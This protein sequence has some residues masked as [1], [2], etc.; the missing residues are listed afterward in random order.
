MNEIE[1]KLEKVFTD[2]ANTRMA[3][4]PICNPVLRVQAVG[5]R[6]WQEHWVGV[7]V[8]PWTISL[9]LMPGEKGPLKTLGADEK[10]TWE[11]PSGNYEFMGLNEP[12]LGSCQVCSLISPV[13]DVA[14][15][16]DAVTI[17]GQVMEALFVADNS[18]QR[19]DAQRRQEFETARMQGEPVLDKPLSR[20]DFLR[21]N[22]LGM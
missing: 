7:L 18:D 12:A 11:F 16:E 15:H 5:F 22:F 21:G 3:G 8:T 10:M 1:Q 4:L 19:R 9:V 2:I 13:G 17:A 20:R 14:S 6:E